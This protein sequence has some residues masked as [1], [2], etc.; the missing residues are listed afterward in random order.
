MRTDPTFS[1]EPTRLANVVVP[2]FRGQRDAFEPVSRPDRSRVELLAGVEA[3]DDCAVFRFHGD[4]ELVAGSDYVRGPKFRLYEMGYLAEYDLGYYLVVANLSDIAAMGARPI[5]LLS[6][7]RYPPDMTDAVFERVLEGIRDACAA[8]GCPNVGG[9]IGGAERLILSASALG[10]CPAGGVLFRAG[11]KPGD[12]ICL[13]APTGFAGAAMAYLRAAD[14]H[15]VIEERHLE[16]MLAYWRRPVA[17]VES[18]V[19]LSASGVVTSCQDT[20]DGL[21]AALHGLA[22]AGAVG[23][24]VHERAL[25]VPGAVSAVAAHLGLDP[26]S[27]VFGDS[28]DFELLFTAPED[29]LGRLADRLDFHQVGVV[30]EQRDVVL[31]RDDGTRTELPGKA[32]RHAPRDPADVGA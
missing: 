19:A 25:L 22:S 4:H 24:E 32:W 8:S 10:V 27:V 9:D 2:L 13:T 26:L 11:A 23:V 7:V 12:A 20:S 30:T 6:V 1:D 3:Q 5:G 18:G 15:P 29:Q 31:V 14:P 28:V 17:R 21:K 16:T